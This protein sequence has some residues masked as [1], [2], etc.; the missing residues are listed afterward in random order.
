[1]I[2][3]NSALPRRNNCERCESR[4]YSHYY[5][6][7]NVFSLSFGCFKF[8]VCVCVWF[9]D[10]AFH[11]NTF[12]NGFIN[13]FAQIF[14]MTVKTELLQSKNAIQSIIIFFSPFYHSLRFDIFIV[15]FSFFLD[16]QWETEQQQQWIKWQQLKIQTKNHIHIYVCMENM[17]DVKQCT[18]GIWPYTDIE[19]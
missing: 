3:S 8:D 9:D 11:T 15:F 5:C 14:V 16:S 4:K 17:Q 19:R 13:G 18:D 6:C 7:W 1:M 12:S 10:F 2:E